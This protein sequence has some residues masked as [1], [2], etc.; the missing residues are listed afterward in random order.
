MAC[1]K[2]GIP[3]VTL[4]CEGFIAQSR[5][6]ARGLGLPG[7]PLG[8][9]PGH[10]GVQTD[11]VVRA[12]V[13][14]QTMQQVIDWL[15]NTTVQE[16]D[17]VEARPGDIVFTGTFE[18]VNDYF[19]DKRWSDGSPFVPP[20]KE[21]IEAFLRFTDR[22][23]TE[24]MGITLPDNRR[25]TPWNVAANGVMAGCR[26]EY[27]PVLMAVVEALLD[28][29]YG[30]EHSGNTPGSETLIVL[31]GPIIKQLGFNYEQG[32]MRDG[33]RPNT[34]VG[35]FW[36]LALRNIAGFKLHGTDKGT[37]GNN[38]RVVLAENEDALAKISWQPH[39]ADMGFKAGDN[40]VYITRL[41][42]GTVLPSV[43]GSTPE[44]F[45][46]YIA[47]GVAKQNGWE[48]IFTV[49]NLG[50]GTLR[51]VL[52]LTPILAE[53]I[54]KA[55]WSKDDLKRYLFD[56]ARLP[57]HRVEDYTER[58]TNHPIGSLVEHAR[59]GKIPSVFAES[60]DPNR[61]VPLVFQPDHF[62][63]LVSGDPLRTNAYTFAHNGFLG[64]PV[65]RKIQLP[66]NWIPPAP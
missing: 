41:T 66:K 58:W 30:L 17:D 62:V 7:L 33:F 16:N 19:Y 60:E 36:R 10:T 25:V 34:T 14:A 50:Y 52:I 3:T 4:I 20:T 38:F 21:K 48:I 29:N 8:V 45:M 61:L 15:I 63:V 11:D 27:M 6:T 35:R 44:E 12:N 43:T 1:E 51:P 18:E 37:F 39:S 55:G 56:H 46:P 64:F 31:N 5:A 54:A 24:V 9:L 53:A 2:V 26:P 22:A 65:A 28:P 57:A 59:L 13:R 47:D 42:G 23:P 40:T 49:G 32:V